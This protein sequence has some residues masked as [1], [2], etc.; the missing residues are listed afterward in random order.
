MEH[1][2]DPILPPEGDGHGNR[3]E[4]ADLDISAL[5]VYLQDTAFENKDAILDVLTKKYGM[6][7]R[8]NLSDIEMN[9]TRIFKRP[10]M[11]SILESKSG[12]EFKGEPL[13]QRDP[14]VIL[15]LPLKTQDGGEYT[16]QIFE[17]FNR[18]LNY[19]Y[20]YILDT[21]KEV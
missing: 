11:K 9:M 3:F 18:R 4:S 20:E 1:F 8:D 10:D 5:D 16:L 2:H 21:I 14:K 15:N 17:V 6:A 12:D 19:R 7:L 13:S